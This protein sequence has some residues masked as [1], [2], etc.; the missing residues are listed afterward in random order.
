MIEEY[1]FR[2]QGRLSDA[3]L[4]ALDGL[5]ASPYAA[6]TVMTGQVVDEAALHGLIARFESLGLQLTEVRRLPPRAATQPA[7]DCH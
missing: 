1:E 2:V 6:E 7:P 4:A 5:Q 3:T